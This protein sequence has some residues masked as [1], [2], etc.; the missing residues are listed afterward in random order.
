IYST[1]T[2]LEAGTNLV[3]HIVYTYDG[4]GNT[5]TKTI[6][7]NSGTT[8]NTKYEKYTFN[9][10][11]V[12]QEKIFYFDGVTI[13]PG[14]TETGTPDSKWHKSS[15]FNGLGQ[16]QDDLIYS[17][18][19]DLEGNLNL[20]AHIVYTYDGSGN[21]LTKSI[22][23]NSGTTKNNKYE[24]Y[25]FNAAGTL[26]EKIFYFDGLTIAPGVTETG[27]SDNKW[28]KS[29]SFIT[30]TGGLKNQDDLIYSTITDLEAGTNLVV[31]IVYT[32]DGAGN[33]LTKTIY[34]NSGTTKNT[35]YEKY[36]FNAAGVLQEKI[37]YFDG[38]TIA[39]GITET[40]TP[41]SKWHKSSNFTAAWQPQDDLIYNTLADL[42]AG[43]NLVNHITY[44]YYASEMMESKTLATQ[45]SGGNIYYHYLN[46]DWNSQ[47]LGRTDRT[48]RQSADSD[49]CLSY[50]YTYWDDADGR[51]QTKSGY[52]DNNWST[53]KAA[54][55]YYNNGTNRMAEK[56][57]TSADGSGNIDYKYYDEAYYGTDD[58]AT[59]ADE[60]YGRLREKTLNTAES[61][62]TKKYVYLS[63]WSGSDRAAVT[64]AYN[65]SD[66]LIEKYEQWFETSGSYR[67]EGFKKYNSSDTQV[68]TVWWFYQY[69]DNDNNPDNGRGDGIYLK[70]GVNIFHV[71]NPRMTHDIASGKWFVSQLADINNPWGS[72]IVEYQYTTSAPVLYLDAACTQVLSYSETTGVFGTPLPAEL[73]YAEPLA[74]TMA[75]TM[76]APLGETE[77]TTI[78]D[79]E[80]DARLGIEGQLAQ[81]YTGSQ[82]AGY[83]MSPAMVDT[84]KTKDLTTQLN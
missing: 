66:A 43:T 11:G 16:P 72:P 15:N 23:D 8:K 13:A 49:G 7:D 21:I 79:P 62:G 67:I 81:T 20:V 39:P 73:P 61:N 12:L 25:T 55:T 37:F 19:T 58:P 24:K 29:S 48:K 59:T 53:L 60:R 28:H 14:I 2:D 68:Q 57:L 63:Y 64:E 38:V 52:T 42:E 74:M 35:K 9:A 1:I 3:V 33:T 56:E 77:T 82:D 41:D 44:T 18:I 45:D 30:T 17:S 47:G 84:T 80:V 5:L 51:L 40:G 32:Y 27:T 71:Y 26:L 4:A 83:T 65:A 10:A 34:D 75:L 69:F 50:A 22:Y 6:Y 46:E 36:T 54:Y 31:H 78:T 76:S 70:I